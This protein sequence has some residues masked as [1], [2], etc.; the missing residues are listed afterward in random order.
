VGSFDGKV[1]IVTGAASGIG[2]ASARRFAREGASVVVADV[3]E[4]WGEETAALIAGDGGTARFV[5][6]DVS[7]PSQVEAMV[8]AAVGAFGRLDFAHNNAGIIQPQHH[9]ADLPIDVWDHGIGVMLT[10]VFLCMKYEIPKMLEQGGGAIVNTSSGAGLIGFP[11]T[12][13]YVASKHGVLGLTKTAAL[14]YARSGIRINAICPGTARTRMVEEWIG[15]DPALEEQV[16]GL[17]PIGRIAEPDEIAAAAIWLCGDD[18]SFMCGHA[19]SI[20][21]GYV[22]Q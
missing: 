7:D 10:G 22:I 1:A 11:G 9:V 2:R 19:M 16:A 12:A 6:T 13:P 18:A 4:K 17:H 15:G 20:D 14:E 8:D 5:R 21:G 3:D